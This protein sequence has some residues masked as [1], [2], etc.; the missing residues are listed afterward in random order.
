MS[1][2]LTNKQQKMADKY[3]KSMSKAIDQGNLFASNVLD[4]LSP[5]TI[6][7]SFQLIMNKGHDHEKNK[8]SD[9]E[10]NYKA[11]NKLSAD[12]I[13][14]LNDVFTVVTR[15]LEESNGDEI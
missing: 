6:N 4:S 7:E 14:Q 13:I 11:G 5:D 12:E 3:S 15:R 1:S 8:I 10:E 9:I 2:L